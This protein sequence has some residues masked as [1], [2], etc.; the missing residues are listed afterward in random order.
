[1]EEIDLKEL[2]DY[3]LKELGVI[4]LF[5]ITTLAVG[6]FYNLYLKTPL[7]KSSTSIVLASENSSSTITQ[8][9]ININKNLVNTYTEI[10]KSK[11]V[12]KETISHLNLDYSFQE[13]AK[14]VSVSVIPET[15]II[16]IDVLDKNANTSQK[17]ANQIAIIFTEKVKDIYD[18]KNV[19]IL[20]KAEVPT[21]A[22]NINIVKE[23]ILYLAAGLMLGLIYAFLRFYFDRNIKNITEVETKMELP[24]MG[25]VRDCAKVMKKENNKKVLISV[26]PKSN[27]AE[28]VK[29]IRTNLDFSKVDQN[30]KTILI[31]SSIPG[32][33]KSFISANLAASFAQ[34]NK[35][36]ILIDCDL[37]KGVI[38]KRMNVNN[39]GLSNL[40][41]KGDLSDLDEYIQ[42]SDVKNLDVITRGIVP[43]NPSELLSSKAFKSIIKLLEGYYDYVI[44]D[45]PSVTN[46]PDSL[47][48]STLVDKTL[49][50]S[51]I[52]YTPLSLLQNTKKS[53]ENV[54]APIAGIIVN[55]VPV[56]KG[57]YYYS[58]YKYE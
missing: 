28:D 27:F 16:N 21:R 13:L 9:D 14:H 32:E 23:T 41:A 31:T 2:F 46:L 45:G 57:G 37:R 36:V 5:S 52:G 20:D 25:S 3:I 26:M 54:N 19:N 43:P 15:E 58:D 49:I 17:I 39:V 55:K 24:I 56:K 50:V 38:H 33:G 44:L 29:T 42:E 51:S 6:T 34:N 11:V 35:K 48:M 22:S 18:M 10:I 30:M 7:Y 4:I 40:I 8:T 53:L 47:I 1:M 12:L